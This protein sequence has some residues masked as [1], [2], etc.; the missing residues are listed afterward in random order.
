MSLLGNPTMTRTYGESRIEIGARPA[1]LFNEG[2][3]GMSREACIKA[4]RAESVA[5]NAASAQFQYNFAAYH[6]AQW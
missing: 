3:A 6:E 5:A 4:L 2:E 1:F